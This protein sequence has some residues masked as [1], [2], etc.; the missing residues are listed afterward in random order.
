[1]NA[2]GSKKSIGII[3]GSLRRESFSRKVAASLADM[4]AP[5]FDVKSIELGGLPIFNQDLDDEG[6]PP[7]AWRDFRREVAAL[8]GVVF[9]TPEYNRS[10]PALLKNAL[11]I[12]SRPPGQNAWDGKPG[13]IVGVSPGR[14]GALA[15]VQSFKQPASFLGLILMPTPEAY[16]SQAA[17][18]FDARGRLSDASARQV[19]QSFSSAFIRWVERWRP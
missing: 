10:M 4:L 16:L 9:V 12:A 8:D 13:A 11:D 6:R 17:D 3:A 1:M 14:L 5:S 2:K 15:A 19:L 7:T 18:L